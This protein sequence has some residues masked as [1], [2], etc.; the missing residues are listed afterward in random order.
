M[1]KRVYDT[2]LHKLT[3]GFAN[4]INNGYTLKEDNMKDRL[5]PGALAGIIG[6]SIQT[7]YAL[8][9]KSLRITDR[10]F[11][12]FGK[13]LMMTNPYKGTLAF[14]V[15]FAAHLFLGALAGVA[16]S[17]IIKYTSSRF[18]LLKGLGAGLVIWTFGLGIATLY[19]LPL[20]GTIKPVPSIVI[21]I[22]SLIYGLITA[23]A[24]KMITNNFRSYFAEDSPSQKKR[25]PIKYRLLTV[26]ARKLKKEENKVKVKKPFKTE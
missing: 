8:T 3:V 16:L 4:Y 24:L 21:L 1:A 10:V 2:I 20:F 23:I 7:I 18:Y 6:A 17:Y 25:K 11:T 5:T 9:V 26:P 19:K 15:G 13:V 12:D 22:G 14:I